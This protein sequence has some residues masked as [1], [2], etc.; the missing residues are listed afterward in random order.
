MRID[1]QLKAEVETIFH[2][3]GLT[4]SEAIKI[5]SQLCATAEVYRFNYNWIQNS[6]SL[7]SSA[8][9]RWMPSWEH[10]H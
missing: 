9:A 8:K 1:D 4:T 6:M 5:F 10:I 3:L 7:V 2:Q